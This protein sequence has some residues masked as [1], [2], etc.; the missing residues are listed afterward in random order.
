MCSVTSCVQLFV[1]PW[2]VAR[3]GP[4]SMEF[5]RQEYWSGLPF[6]PPGDI[7]SPGI[8]PESPASPALQ[9]GA[10]REDPSCP[11][12]YIEAIKHR[13]LFYKSHHVCCTESLSCV[14]LFATPCTAAHQ[15]LL[16][17]GFTRQESWNGLLFPP[18]GGLPNPWM[19]P[20]PLVSPAL[21]G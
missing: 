1:P 11:E 2:I 13:I 7:L 15:V 14:R 20:Q 6:P 16:S 21:A 8:E 18:P 9:A 10:I 17:M 3:Q 5:S 4:P 19:E 12:T